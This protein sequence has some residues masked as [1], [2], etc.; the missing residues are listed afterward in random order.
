MDIARHIR[1]AL[2]FHDLGLRVFEQTF[3]DQPGLAT[4]QL[5]TVR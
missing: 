2:P 3:V 4:G 5:V 1:L